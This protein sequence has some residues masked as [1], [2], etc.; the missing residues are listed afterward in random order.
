M[1]NLLKKW[2]KKRLS[3]KPHL[4]LP[5]LMLILLDCRPLQYAGPGSE[6][7][8]LIFSAV[9]ALAAEKAV[10]WLFVADH[11]YRPGDFPELP[12]GTVLIRRAL[13]G[14]PGCRYWD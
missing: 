4:E 3:G 6:K 1:F 11:S 9:A 7:N 12:P 2:I 8:R 14:R 5:L 10:K 13:P